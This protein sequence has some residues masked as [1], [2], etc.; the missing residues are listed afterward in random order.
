MSRFRQNANPNRL[1]ELDNLFWQASTARQLWPQPVCDR[2]Q[3]Y[4]DFYNRMDGLSH[5]VVC[6]SCGTIHHEN[7]DLYVVAATAEILKP[8]AVDPSLVPFPFSCGL[9]QLDTENIMIDP[10]AIDTERMDSISICKKCYAD[11]LRN[12]RPPE[13]LANYRWVGPRPSELDDLT[14]AEEA[15]IARS[16]MFGRI[17]RLEARRGGEPKY[18]SLKGHIVLVPQNTMRLLDILPMSPSSLHD[19][20]HVVWVG[21]AEPDLTKIKP[22]FTVHK[23]KVIKAL[24]FLKANHE[25]YKNVRIDVEE[26][27]RWPSVFITETLLSNIGRVRSGSPEDAERDGFATEDI[28]TA[29]FA[30]DIPITSSAVV[31]TNNISRPRNIMT[32]ERLES[33]SENVSINVVPGTSI[34]EQYETPSY[35]TSAF[36]TLFPWGTGKHKDDRRTSDG[37]RLSLR[38]WTDLLLRNSS[39]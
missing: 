28:D 30:G 2:K 6:A 22:Q 27:D 12:S 14:W 18:S 20:A 11:L 37:H 10:L 1:A 38:K 19:L 39:R 24:T 31:D 33:L 3:L 26:L 34:L 36:P 7:N 4:T 23:N 32:L 13:A 25:D 8:L 21:K 35:F 9:P 16:H 15:L 5:N 17:F 29:D